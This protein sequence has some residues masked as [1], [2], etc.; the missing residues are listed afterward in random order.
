MAETVIRKIENMKKV[1]LANVLFLIARLGLKI[2]EVE[3]KVGVST[4][5]LSRLKDNSTNIKLE[6]VAALAEVL[7]YPMDLLCTVDLTAM[8][9]NEVTAVLFISK[10]T[11]ETVKG[12][13][14]W[15]R[16]SRKDA[17]DVIGYD[18]GYTSHPLFR[19]RDDRMPY[20][21]STFAQQDGTELAGDTL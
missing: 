16:F 14:R 7:G 12:T 2:G 20:F 10:L 4:G 6:L 19:C 5:Y 21:N 1:I 13:R 17:K 3:E 9:P 15:D 8:T 11:D 18:S